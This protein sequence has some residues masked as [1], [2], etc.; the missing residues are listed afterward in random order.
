MHAREVKKNNSK[1]MA[2]IDHLIGNLQNLSTLREYG[3]HTE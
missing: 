3:S 1:D 2:E